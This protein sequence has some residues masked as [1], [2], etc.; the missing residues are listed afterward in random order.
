MAAVEGTLESY[1]A[2]TVHAAPAGF[3]PNIDADFRPQS[4]DVRLVVNGM[5]AEPFTLGPKQDLV[6]DDLLAG[7]WRVKAAWYG[8]TLLDVESIEV[9]GRASLRCELPAAAIEGHDREAWLR[10][11][12]EYPGV[13]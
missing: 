6:I 3:G 12:R 7:I 5:P 8:E 2:D 11:G 9:E 1:Y 13:E 4:L 10:A